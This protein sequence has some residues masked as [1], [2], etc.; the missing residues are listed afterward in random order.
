MNDTLY[1]LKWNSLKRIESGQTVEMEIANPDASHLSGLAYDSKRDRLVICSYGGEGYFDFY[2]LGDDEWLQPSTLNNK[3][4][5]GLTYWPEH[6][7]LYALKLNHGE[8]DSTRVLVFEPDGELVKTIDLAIPVLA[9][10]PR[11]QTQGHDLVLYSAYGPESNRY[12]IDI[13]TGEVSGHFRSGY[14]G[15]RA[16]LVSVYEASSDHDTLGTMKVVVE[17]TAPPVLVL[18][19]Y[20]G[21]RW[22]IQGGENLEKVIANGYERPEVLGLSDGCELTTLN[23]AA[24]TEYLP[25]AHEVQSSDMHSL[26]CELENRGI[27]VDSIACAYQAQKAI[28]R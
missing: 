2:Q 27:G 14:K 18:N 3:D 15:R 10:E 9:A 26:L 17:E 6:D 25:I 13:G 23:Y 22:E 5:Q 16:A 20:E 11:L 19:S 8:G 28:I 7:K 21:V 1:E 4:I 12:Y 24:G